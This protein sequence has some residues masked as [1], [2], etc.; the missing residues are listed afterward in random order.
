MEMEADWA[1][2]NE[3]TWAYFNK[4]TWALLFNSMNDGDGGRLGFF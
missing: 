1:S 3:W 4:W 2:F